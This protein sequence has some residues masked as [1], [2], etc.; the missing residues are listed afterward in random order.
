MY[1]QSQLAMAVSWVLVVNVVFSITG[2]ASLQARQV[3]NMTR[4]DKP[5]SEVRGGGMYHRTGQWAQY[6]IKGP[7]DQEGTDYYVLLSDKG[8][9]VAKAYRVCGRPTSLGLRTKAKYW[10]ELKEVASHYPYYAPPPNGRAGFSTPT[11]PAFAE[12]L[13]EKDKLLPSG[14]RESTWARL[15]YMMWGWPFYSECGRSSD[16]AKVYWDRTVRPWPEVAKSPDQLPGEGTI[17]VFWRRGPLS[18]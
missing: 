12:P 5:W 14:V 2:C 9:V 17:T 1:R 10:A 15:V 18:R 7:G 4:M 16:E 11:Y 6:S 8:K 13:S 3:F